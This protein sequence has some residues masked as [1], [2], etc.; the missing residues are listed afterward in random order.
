VNNSTRPGGPLSTATF[1]SL[2]VNT[3][4]RLVADNDTVT[5]LLLDL[6]QNCSSRYSTNPAPVSTPLAVNASTPRPEQVIQYY[7][8]SSIALTLDGYNNT[9]TYAPAG[10]PDSP[11]PSN[12]DTT[13]LTCLNQSI[14]VSAPLVG[15]GIAVWTPGYFNL[16]GVVWALWALLRLS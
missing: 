4:F 12:I 6:S 8:A 11:L 16:I 9:A 2:S 14:G 13:L 10:T 7:R 15:G 5:S 1:H 3:T